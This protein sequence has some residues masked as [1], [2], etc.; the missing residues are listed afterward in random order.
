[1]ND[2]MTGRQLVAR[3]VVHAVELALEGAGGAGFYRAQGLERRF[4]DI[5]AARYH[6]MQSGPF[7]EFSGATAL[8]LPTDKIF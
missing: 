4:R 3:H 8:G 2:V 6:P 1:V 5:Q 7:A